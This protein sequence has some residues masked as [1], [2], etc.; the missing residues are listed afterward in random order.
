MCSGLHWAVSERFSTLCEV[1]LVFFLEG[2]GAFGRFFLFCFKCKVAVSFNRSGDILWNVLLL[3][4]FLI[5]SLSDR[6]SHNPPES[7]SG[8]RCRRSRRTRSESIYSCH[9]QRT[10]LWCS[11]GSR[12]RPGWGDRGLDKNQ[13]DRESVILSMSLFSLVKSFI[14]LFVMKK[15]SGLKRSYW[16]LLLK[17]THFN[18]FKIK[19][20]ISVRHL[21]G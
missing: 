2:A 6:V 5:A 10:T 15:S 8:F 3:L 14:D 4:L 7:W 20:P 16:V 13:T 9:C 21:G 17:I 1:A 11:S 12:R 19:Y 18:W